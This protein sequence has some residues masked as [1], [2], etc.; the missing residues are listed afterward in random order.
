MHNLVS[1]PCTSVQHLVTSQLEVSE[2]LGGHY[3][4]TGDCRIPY[5][6]SDRS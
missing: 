5:V 2:V 4:V 1:F 6:I 3:S